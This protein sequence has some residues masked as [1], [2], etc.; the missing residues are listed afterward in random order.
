MTHAGPPVSVEPIHPGPPLRLSLAQA[1]TPIP[2]AIHGALPIDTEGT[3]TGAV[4]V[5]GADGVYRPAPAPPAQQR[6]SV[7]HYLTADPTGLPLGA[8]AGDWVAVIAGPNAGTV[9]HVEET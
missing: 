4:L 1:G 2:T 6:G 3:T 7:V 9:Y 5:A 8:I